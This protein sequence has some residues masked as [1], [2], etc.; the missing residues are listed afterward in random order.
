MDM[1]MIR[2]VMTLVAF[3]TFIGIIAWAWSGQRR[4]DFDE[5]AL[6]PFD[7]EDGELANAQKEPK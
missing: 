1:V 3:L 2:S 7:N 4:A 6:L 5:A